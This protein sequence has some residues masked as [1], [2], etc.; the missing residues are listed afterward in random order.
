MR[1]KSFH[2]PIKLKQILFQLFKIKS[3]FLNSIVKEEKFYL[4]SY[5]NKDQELINQKMYKVIICEF[6]ASSFSSKIHS[7]HIEF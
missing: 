3:F 2:F 7:I 6:I 4:K 1:L 5:K